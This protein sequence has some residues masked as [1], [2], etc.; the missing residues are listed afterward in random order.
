MDDP[1]TINESPV[2]ASLTSLVRQITLVAG[3][4]MVGKGYL[5]Q[6]TAAA[7]GSI[8]VIAAPLVWGQIKQWTR[9]NELVSLAKQVPDS[10]ATVKT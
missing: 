10:V 1:I 3:G 7:I 4:W 2:P 6:S 5:D 8:L 9:H